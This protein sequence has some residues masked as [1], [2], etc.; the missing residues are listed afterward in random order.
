MPDFMNL[1]PLRTL[2]EQA[3][4]DTCVI[5]RVTYGTDNF[6]GETQIIT[7]LGTYNCRLREWGVTPREQHIMGMMQIS[8]AYALFLPYDT[9]VENEDRVSFNSQLFEV[10]DADKHQTINVQK[11]VMLRD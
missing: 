4:D 8:N 5:R 6:G 11:K 7:T 3:M 9:D 2:A 1:S 10:I